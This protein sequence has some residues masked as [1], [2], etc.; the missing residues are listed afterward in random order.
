MT[1]SNEKYVLYFESDIDSID[2]LYFNDNFSF[3]MP[4]N[5]ELNEFLF[6]LL[7]ANLINE[8]AEEAKK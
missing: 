3:L 4:K 7:F 1:L 8:K 5:G 2:L 6:N